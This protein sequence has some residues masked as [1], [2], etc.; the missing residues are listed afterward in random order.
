MES[1]GD[2]RVNR[3]IDEIY[4]LRQKIS[5]VCMGEDIELV[6]LAISEFHVQVMARYHPEQD[7]WDLWAKDRAFIERQLDAMVRKKTGAPLPD[8]TKQH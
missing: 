8:W 1:E 3:T 6:R 5:D 4:R 7:A 2:R